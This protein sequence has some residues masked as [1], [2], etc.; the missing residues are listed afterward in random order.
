MSLYKYVVPERIDVLKNL[1]MRFTQQRVLN[2]QF[3]TYPYFKSFAPPERIKELVDS[4]G[5]SDRTIEELAYKTFKEEEE[6]L[7]INLPKKEKD[8]LARNLLN[9]IGNET[10]VLREYITS[11]TDMRKPYSR[12]ILIPLI[13][14]GINNTFGILSL[15]ENDDNILMWSHYSAHHTGFV[16]EFDDNNAFFSK[17]NNISGIPEYVKKVHYSKDRPELDVFGKEGDK[18]RTIENWI[19][20]VYWLKSIDWK[21]EKE[22]R[23]IKKFKNWKG[24]VIKKDGATDPIYLLPFQAEC[25]KSVIFGCKINEENKK[26]IL[27]LLKSD[28]KYYHIIPKQASQDEKYYK[29][30]IHNL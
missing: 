11:L 9:K 3:E 21:Y 20:K 28:S 5:L 6:R 25:I 19:N 24:S 10:E 18:E 29:L 13:L 26:S 12:K 30:N 23:M 27:N 2:D 17:T 15:S 1:C 16:I 4:I 8:R 7:G 22:W 14:N